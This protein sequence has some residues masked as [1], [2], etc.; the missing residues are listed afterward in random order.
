M[1]DIIKCLIKADKLL[2]EISAK[3]EDVFLMAEARKLMKLAF[4]ELTKPKET[5]VEND[6]G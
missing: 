6:G 5:E 1:D 4:D 3:G 2:S